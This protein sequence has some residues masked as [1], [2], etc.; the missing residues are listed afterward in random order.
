VANALSS[1][2][3]RADFIT[4]RLGGEG[5]TELI[6][7]L[8][9]NNFQPHVGLDAAEWPRSVKKH[10]AARARS[11]SREVVPILVAAARGCLSGQTKRAM[12]LFPDACLS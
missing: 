11:T 2:K 12:A 9:A 6:D 5:V 7:Q 4:E 8:L 3:E 1:V 10:R